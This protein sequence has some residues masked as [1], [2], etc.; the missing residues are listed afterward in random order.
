MVKTKYYLKIK[1]KKKVLNYK[2]RYY[3]YDQNVL[4]KAYSV[5]EAWVIGIDY[6]MTTV[7][8]GECTSMPL[9]LISLC[10]VGYYNNLEDFIHVNLEN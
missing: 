6:F 10:V 3:C 2:N 4:I 7:H 5:Q 1:Y 9:E 8:K